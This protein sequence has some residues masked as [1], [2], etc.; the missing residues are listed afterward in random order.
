MIHKLDVMTTKKEVIPLDCIEQLK[1]R[2]ASENYTSDQAMHILSYCTPASYDKNHDLVVHTI[3][4]EISKRS[5]ILNAV[6]YKL[7]LRYYSEVGNPS[8]AQA[9]FDRLGK[10]IRPLN[11]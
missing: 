9:M 11:R 1:K 5:H 8:G 2:L 3:W 10:I 6:H 4:T 7:M